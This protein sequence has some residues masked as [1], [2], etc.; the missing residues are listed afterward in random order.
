MVAFLFMLVALALLGHKVL[1]HITKGCHGVPHVPFHLSF[2]D[3][4][5]GVQQ[6]E[7][8]NTRLRPLLERHGATNI[9]NAGQWTLLVTKPKYLAQIFR[10]ERAI[11][12]GGFYRKT[13]RGAMASLFGE[14]IIDSHGDVWKQFSAIMKPS[15]RRVPDISSLNVAAEKLVSLLAMRQ[16][17]ARPE[18]GIIINTSVQQWALDVFG[19]CFLDVNFGCLD[20]GNCIV[21]KALQG[22]LMS[23][24]GPL[25]L[26]FPLLERVCWLLLPSRRRSFSLVRDLEKVLLEQTDTLSV[27]LRHGDTHNQTPEKLI[28]RLK[29]AHSAC[30]MSDF[31]YRSNLKMMLFAGHENAKSALVSTLWE[32]ANQPRILEKLYQEIIS[33]PPDSTGNLSAL[34]YLTT[35][36]Y[37]TLRLYPPLSQLINRVTSTTI[38]LDDGITIPRGTWVGWSAYGVHTD[39]NVWG[40]SANE[41]YPERW[42]NDI[43]TI[44][45]A[46]RR[47]QIAG[48]FIAFGAY[49]RMCIGSEFAVV[50]LQITLS[51]IVRRFRW[52][53]DPRY[54]P[55]MSTWPSLA[56]RGKFHELLDQEQWFI[57]GDNPPP[58]TLIVIGCRE[59]FDFTLLFE[60]LIFSIIPAGGQLGLKVAK[61]L[62][63]FC[64][65]A[66]QL[67]LVIL[68]ATLHHHLLT[69]AVAAS[70]LSLAAYAML[71]L[72]SYLAH[73]RSVKP[74]TILNSYLGLTC[75]FDVPQ[76]RTLWL[77]RDI[78]YIS[79]VFTAGLACKAITV[80]LEMVEKRK[81]LKFQYQRWPPEALAGVGNRAVFWWLNPLLL[82]GSRTILGLANLFDLD[83]ELTSKILR[84]RFRRIEENADHKQPQPLLFRIAITLW[85]P[86]LGIVVPRLF[87]IGFKI[88][89]PLL[90]A[91]AVMLLAEPR[92]EESDNTGRALV[93]ATTLIYTG[94]A[95]SSA[96][97]QHQTYRLITMVR[98][99]LVGLI[100]DASCNLESHATHDSAAVTL[101]NTDIDR[102]AAGL[103]VSDNLW[104]GPVEL[105]IAFYLLSRY[106][107]W[108]CLA[109]ALL[110]LVGI[111]CSTAISR[112]SA[113]AQKTWVE[114]VEHRVAAT[115]SIL[116]QFKCI[117]MMGLS[118]V[119]QSQLHSLRVLELKVSARFR[120]LLSL[121]MVMAHMPRIAVPVLTLLIYVLATRDGLGIHLDLALAFTTISLCSLIS[122]TLNSM[123]R[124][125]PDFAAAIGCFDRIERYLDSCRAAKP[126][127]LFPNNADENISPSIT[128]PG[129]EEVLLQING[130]DFAYPGRSEPCLRNISFTVKAGT[131]TALVG[132]I[133]SGKSSLLL[134]MLGEM[135]LVKGYIRRAP[136]LQVSYCAQNPWLPRLS[137]RNIVMG[138][139]EMN[140]R[141]YEDI[142]SACLLQQDI[143]ELPDGDETV[144]GSRGGRLSGG[145]KQRLSL[146]RA[147]YSR[148]P[149]LILDDVL[150][151]LDQITERQVIQN[152]C[153]VNG[154]CRRMGITVVLAT[155]TVRYAQQADQV[156]LMAPNGTINQ[157]EAPSGLSLDR[158]RHP[159]VPAKD[160]KA[161]IH[162]PVEAL[163]LPLVSSDNPAS[164]IYNDRTR[165][166]GDIRLY[167]YYARAIGWGVALGVLF[168]DTALAFT[169]KLPALWIKWWSNA[170][171]RQPGINTIM[172]AGIFGSLIADMSLVD[173]ELP[174]YLHITLFDVATCIVEAGLILSA[175]KW[176]ALACPAILA[177]LYLLQNFYLRTSRQLRLLDL[178]TKSPLYSHIMELLEGLVTVRA[179]HWQ[180]Y[181]RSQNDIYL[182]DSQRPFYLLY[183]IQRWLNLV[184]D[185]VVAALATI[186]MALATQIPGT[187]AGALGLSLVNILSFSENLASVVRSWTQ[188]ETSLGAVARVKSFESNTPSEHLPP[189]KLSTSDQWPSQGA[190][191]IRDLSASYRLGTPPALKDIS[192]A[193]RP[194][195][196]IGICGRTGSG[197]SSFILTLLRLAEIEHGEIIIDD[198]SINSVPRDVIRRAI[199]TIPQDPAILPCT[200]R[201]NLDP[202]KEHP[203]DAL[204]QALEEV[205]IW[206]AL[207]PQKGLDTN[208]QTSPL[209]RGQEQ[210]LCLAR[211]M[212][213]QSRIVI[214]DEVT[215]SVDAATEARMMEVMRQRLADCTVIAVAHRL[216]TIRNFD[217]IVVLDQGCLVEC[218]TPDEL[219]EQPG[220]YF[221]RVWHSQSRNY[222]S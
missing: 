93:A 114:A 182:D 15:I 43:N 163:T 76:A 100:Y 101:V 24:G 61:Q 38:N 152:V 42:G 188:L 67:A 89:Q 111:G 102:I 97:Y 48:S 23:F 49:S 131:W 57:N 29:R 71:A 196:K 133:G 95:L 200:V 166:T 122:E 73:D 106:I 4:C 161:A 11:T 151:A 164:Q 90:I 127:E 116:G 79:A 2:Y 121:T 123:S 165:Q 158:D 128:Q 28:Y 207:L 206:G 204:V 148:K 137:I 35:V 96:A 136:S 180:D 167:G 143:A 37:E 190:I 157:Q 198:I 159:P 82:Q 201:V 216:Q 32:L 142:L 75:L 138:H 3:F 7:F 105:A 135:P 12:K 60:H 41:Y 185:L 65:I 176:A 220:S 109:P 213:R 86:T 83:Q 20:N 113:D 77:R 124:A 191:I 120:S 126:V 8:Y 192:L 1:R 51:A 215:A 162:H 160:A 98:G 189:E 36:I 5:R 170:E 99:G 118:G 154:L 183:S 119:A 59:Q 53:K 155:H 44:N 108:F 140:Q 178:E 39:P 104:A 25:L 81:A 88:C 168:S 205:G 72:L 222:S 16:R 171:E 153:G 175:S 52:T 125:G 85:R 139:S 147:L 80:V 150:S 50:Q 107:K 181:M 174:L 27:Q 193:I 70:T 169:L 31:H 218:G 17:Q 87:L 55:S 177:I 45:R 58:E 62:A 21:Q 33:S 186:V 141:W 217:R 129:S 10:D 202:V 132:P 209:S 34:P 195:E 26:A 47:H 146:A 115:V 40:P 54:E 56:S 203:D 13:P 130:A 221:R 149:L 46:V 19:E 144:I 6:I 68:W 156:I 112:Y 69:V 173:M 172:F 78:K 210:L 64:L 211:A 22:V 214:L 94:I 145:Q 9:W 84:P 184:L 208:L 63:F 18:E 66:T 179:F 212:L 74:S 91:R 110:A 30:Q 219:L 14:N 134:G 194:G 103:A 92:S 117:K 187:S 197:K 199:A